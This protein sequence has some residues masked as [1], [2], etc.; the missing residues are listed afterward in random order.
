MLKF[1]FFVKKFA[2]CILE[3]AVDAKLLINYT[4]VRIIKTLIFPPLII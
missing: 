2:A 4:H 3:T 1:G